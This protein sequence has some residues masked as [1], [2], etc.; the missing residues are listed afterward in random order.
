[1]PLGDLFPQ[2]VVDR[3]KFRGSLRHPS[4]EFAGDALLFLQETC[5]L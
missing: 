3:G 1:M 4:I 2:F 5:F